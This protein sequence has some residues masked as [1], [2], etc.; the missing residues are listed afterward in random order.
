MDFLA[1]GDG[2]GGLPTVLNLKFFLDED[3]VLSSCPV[4]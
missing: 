4:R 1:L 3:E 2:F